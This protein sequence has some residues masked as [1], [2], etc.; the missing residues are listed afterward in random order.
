MGRR[1]NGLKHGCPDGQMDGWMDRYGCVVIWLDGQIS[2]WMHVCEW[3]SRGMDGLVDGQMDEELGSE[4]V[5]GWVGSRADGC[6]D[7][8]LMARCMN[9]E[10]EVDGRRDGAEGRNIKRADL[11]LLILIIPTAIH[12][13]LTYNMGIIVFLAFSDDKMSESIMHMAPSPSFLEEG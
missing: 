13:I 12:G 8:G 4:R 5:H 9:G 11:E 1:M 10:V 3:M 6:L 2:E 7:G